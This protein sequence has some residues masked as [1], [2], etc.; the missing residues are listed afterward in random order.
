VEKAKQKNVLGPRK[1]NKPKEERKA[2]FFGGEKT[3]ITF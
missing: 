3:K 1:R 2:H